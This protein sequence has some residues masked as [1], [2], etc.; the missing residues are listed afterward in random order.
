MT[1]DQA[2]TEYNNSTTTESVRRSYCDYGRSCES[3]DEEQIKCTAIKMATTT[4]Q[5]LGYG[6]MDCSDDNKVHALQCDCIT[7]L[8]N[9]DAFFL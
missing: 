2:Q 6:W 1:T 5:R 4:E 9:H 8:W 7:F 3:E